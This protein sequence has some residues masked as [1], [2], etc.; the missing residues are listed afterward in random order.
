MSDINTCDKSAALVTKKQSQ[1]NFAVSELQQ[2]A[3]TLEQL[4][5][6]LQ[7]KLEPVLLEANKPDPEQDIDLPETCAVGREIRHTTARL[8]RLKT[9][10]STIYQTLDM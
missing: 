2:E 1:L 3:E 4:I 8:R 7:S 9:V 5:G 6:E 10:C